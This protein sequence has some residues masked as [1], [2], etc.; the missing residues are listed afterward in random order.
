MLFRSFHIVPEDGLPADGTFDLITTFDCLHDMTQPARVVEAIRAAI[1]PDGWWLIA[2]IK[3]R[4]T[5]EENLR[6]NPMAA[7]MYA[8]SVVGCLQT[9]MSEPGGAGLGTLGLPEPTMRELTR[10]A[11]FTRFR[12]LDLPSPINAYYEVRP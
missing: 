11:G 7:R 3:G 10:S 8:T 5:Y 1:R 2:D 12:V 6:D 9:G 4:P